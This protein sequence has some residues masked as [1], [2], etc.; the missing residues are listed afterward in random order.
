[1]PQQFRLLSEL[2]GFKMSDL[3]FDI[4]TSLDVKSIGAVKV[5][6]H[7]FLLDKCL[8]TFLRNSALFARHKPSKFKWPL[9]IQV[10]SRWKLA[11][12]LNSL[13][14]TPY[15]GFT[16]TYRLTKIWPMWDL[17]SPTCELVT[18]THDFWMYILFFRKWIGYATIDP[19]RYFYKSLQNCVC[20]FFF[21]FLLLGPHNS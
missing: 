19:K 16:E 2:Q 21:S 1:M 5:Q 3:E 14:V 9:T 6:I 15:Y 11:A 17:L 18:H 10:H 13:H 20:V 12:P 4:S 7:D 8:V